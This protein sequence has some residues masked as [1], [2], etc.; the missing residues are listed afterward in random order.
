MLVS[1]LQVF[2]SSGG[3]AKSDARGGRTRPR[4]LG[5]DG[6]LWIQF[7]PVRPEPMHD[8]RRFSKLV[9]LTAELQ[10]EA[11]TQRGPKIFKKIKRVF[12]WDK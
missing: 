6:G 3:T 8:G 4:I 9:A 10:I 12:W 11:A 7:Q 5:A 2:P 1:H